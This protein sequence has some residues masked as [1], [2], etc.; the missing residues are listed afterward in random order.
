ME[1]G[2]GYWVNAYEGGEIVVSGGRS[3]R[4]RPNPTDYSEGA[5]VLT[6]DQQ[7]IFFGV[8]IPE[9][10]EIRYELPPLPPEGAQD[11]RYA[12]G[13]KLAKEGGHISIQQNNDQCHLSYQINI[14]AD[15]G[16]E[17]ILISEMGDRYILSDSG[18]IIVER[19]I[20]SMVLK[21]EPIV[22]LSYS[23]SQN[24]PNPF[25]PETAIHFSIKEKNE[26]SL[27]IYDILGKEIIKIVQS[28][29]DP[30]FHKVIWDGSSASGSVVSSGIYFYRITSG[31][32]VNQKKMMLIR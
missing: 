2:K 21:Q 12:D 5:N 11:F 29:M 26:V 9:E 28:H 30:G 6:F 1:P 25:N 27:V 7:S 19:P 24:Y 10:E 13:S 14:P 3:A 18:E 31:D 17:W 32:Y 20:R 8:D 4:V 22:P 23:L 15:E 16:M